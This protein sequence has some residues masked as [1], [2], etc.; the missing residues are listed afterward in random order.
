MNFLN[1]GSEKKS[2][3]SQ[4]GIKIHFIYEFP[5]DLTHP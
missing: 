1:K 2:E 3:K 4:C 5:N